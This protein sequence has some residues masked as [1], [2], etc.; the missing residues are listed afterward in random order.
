MKTKFLKFQKI[1]MGFSFLTISGITIG[2]VLENLNNSHQLN[3]NLQINNKSL[4]TPN[5][6][7][8]SIYFSGINL[9]NY[10]TQNNLKTQYA[11]EKRKV[12]YPFFVPRY[13][14]WSFSKWVDSS[15]SPEKWS[16]GNGLQERLNG[17]REIIL[18]NVELT[19]VSYSDSLI[20]EQINLPV[21]PKDW[22]NQKY[23]INT[24]WT[25][26]FW[27]MGK[28]SYTINAS[29]GQQ[30]FT[31]E[32]SNIDGYNPANDAGNSGNGDD[33]FN[34]DPA[35]VHGGRDGIKTEIVIDKSIA[36]N[37]LTANIY[38]RVTT[39]NRGDGNKYYW[40]GLG[41]T[42]I[43]VK[44]ITPA[45]NDISDVDF[46]N[47]LQK[48]LTNLRYVSDWSNS[49][50][51]PKNWADIQKFITSKI[52][53]YVDSVNKQQNYQKGFDLE[54]NLTN[55]SPNTINLT[56]N[57]DSL[58]GS[59]GTITTAGANQY[60]TAF[61]LTVP[62]K[63]LL[64]DK[65]YGNDAWNNLTFDTN[66]INYDENT[67]QI[68]ISSN[69]DIEKSN[70]WYNLIKAPTPSSN[71]I[72]T[73]GTDS[74][75]HP[76]YPNFGT[77]YL[78]HEINLTYRV[79][80]GPKG[81]MK[82]SGSGPGINVTMQENDSG[83]GVYDARFYD[84]RFDELK[85]NGKIAP[86]DINKP[87][88]WTL[89]IYGN[90]NG[91]Y[92]LQMQMTFIID[93][94]APQ[95]NIS[96]RGWNPTAPVLKDWQD[97]WITQS[98]DNGNNNPLYKPILD[99]ATGLGQEIVWLS[100]NDLNPKA[101]ISDSSLMS[102]YNN[103]PD[104]I[105]SKGKLIYSAVNK[106]SD[107]SLIPNVDTT[108]LNVPGNSFGIITQAYVSPKGINEFV[109]ANQRLFR[110]KLEPKDVNGQVQL[111]IASEKEIIN[112]TDP[113]LDYNDKTGIY[114]YVSENQATAS[115]P[116]LTY[117]TSVVAIDPKITNQNFSQYVKQKLNDYS[118]QNG[119]TTFNENVSHFWSSLAGQHLADYLFNV[120]G[121]KN[122]QITKLSYSEIVSWWNIYVKNAV[123][124]DE[125]YTTPK[126]D[127]SS[128]ALASIKT[129]TTSADELKKQVLVNLEDQ[130]N[131]LAD[132]L[133][134]KKKQDLEK[135]N[136]GYTWHD[137]TDKVHLEYNKDYYISNLNSIN[138]DSLANL[139]KTTRQQSINLNVVATTPNANLVA[140]S[141]TN[142]KVIN[143]LDFN[144]LY[145]L[146]NSQIPVWNANTNSLAVLKQGIS[147]SVNAYLSTATGQTITNNDWYIKESDAEISNLL[148][149]NG[150]T[151]LQIVASDTSPYL[152]NS[153]TITVNN[154]TTNPFD[155]RNIEIPK[156]N[157]NSND[158]GT[159]WQ[160]IYNWVK[161]YVSKNYS[162]L[163]LDTDYK[164][165]ISD[166]DI[167][168][169]V[170]A[171]NNNSGDYIINQV[172]I[173]LNDKTQGYSTL[174]VN[175]SKVN[176]LT[177]N[178]SPV[179]GSNNPYAPQTPVGGNG[180]NSNNPNGPS[181]TSNSGG[182]NESYF[183]NK[184]NIAWVSTVTVAGI[185]LLVFC[186]LVA[187]GA[188]DSRY[189]SWSEAWRDI[190]GRVFSPKYRRYLEEKKKQDEIEFEKIQELYNQPD[191]KEEYIKW[192][193]EIQKSAEERGW[194]YTVGEYNFIHSKDWE[195][196]PIKD[197]P[198][199]IYSNLEIWV[200][201]DE[202]KE[203]KQQEDNKQ[204]S[205]NSNNKSNNKKDDKNIKS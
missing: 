145:N 21:N 177:N 68:S 88:T 43:T 17:K 122:D 54:Y 34:I 178:V 161:E 3:N 29:P 124:I 78:D 79:P 38:L 12:D 69:T 39:A 185:L 168:G 149:P 180:A 120:Q 155:L 31:I 56:I 105:D 132:R 136:K 47:G 159:I 64:S 138:W 133:T 139:N 169:I 197:W 121:M 147:D 127:L 33:G 181:G 123:L 14:D 165:Q 203:E 143:S 92:G 194:K 22:V 7:S 190:T 104:P 152:I 110:F 9:S 150:S 10:K 111:A 146:F 87:T 26:A 37:V 102:Q 162:N 98:L 66:K 16:Y 11:L 186:G 163:I 182:T 50:I 60:K 100:G 61:N 75:T 109:N 74:P 141:S 96:Y 113:S 95:A 125:N 91:T 49:V 41:S 135:V 115:N 199:H 131:H 160:S 103:Y 35:G 118:N 170:D 23:T 184:G 128:L 77:F 67:G 55:S 202:E 48:T 183:S 42:T 94:Y 140:G 27:N 20:Q 116:N 151:N 97:K 70:P 2:L 89:Y 6:T 137:E 196:I 72:Y 58:K 59:S 158:K 130:M 18:N 107:G 126:Y 201:P 142:L 32:D 65:Y 86:S 189:R 73:T 28:T 84:G 101:F 108:N 175:D 187:Y 204:S 171:F 8:N 205:K 179:A 93:A 153:T 148:L 176:E 83:N 154:Q 114:L 188:I 192:W 106:N 1:W 173:P 80:P 52:T 193:L 119:L 63:M 57:Y 71:Q 81:A 53:S 30:I 164:I 191:R 166:A 82:F 36:G 112:N 25:G 156:L 90:K 76:V 51:D 134:I 198:K 172:L 19:Q 85:K 174:V 117:A 99:P 46:N 200:D 13:H 167:N 40:D 144:N 157:I 44:S 5:N 45:L 62:V 129:N 24:N 195:T 4:T 15:Y